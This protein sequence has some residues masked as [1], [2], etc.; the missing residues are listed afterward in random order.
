MAK[1][2]YDNGRFVW[3]G[4]YRTRYE[5]KLAGF[6]W[7][8]DL[9][10]WWTTNTGRAFMLRRYADG[11]AR[12]HLLGFADSETMPLQRR[13]DIH[14]AVK[15]LAAMCDW[16]IMK[17]GCGFSKADTVLGH[18]LAACRELNSQQA[19]KALGLLR[20]HRHQLPGEILI[21]CGAI[22]R[23]VEGVRDGSRN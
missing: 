5:P 1:M 19:D 17:D 15:M 9:K 13:L 6:W 11:K 8:A 16:A 23:T 20:L 14:T 10:R 3:Q 18:E 12:A 21:Q 4:G 7:D 22:R 2:T